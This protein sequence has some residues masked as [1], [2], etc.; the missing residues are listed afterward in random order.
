MSHWKKEFTVMCD[1]MSEVLGFIYMGPTEHDP[2][3]FFNVEF[4]V[5]GN[6]KIP[7]TRRVTDAWRLV[8]GKEPKHAVKCT[9]LD[10]TKTT[11]L[12]DKLTE[13]LD[14]EI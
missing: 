2:T 14:G 10:R 4:Y 7:F 9:M 13:V 3:E 5:Q 12:R 11:Y 6:N 8:R 1:C